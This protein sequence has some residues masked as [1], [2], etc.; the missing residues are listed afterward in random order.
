MSRRGIKLLKRAL[1]SVIADNRRREAKDRNVG[2]IWRNSLKGSAAERSAACRQ[3]QEWL[4]AIRLETPENRLLPSELLRVVAEIRK[5]AMDVR[6]TAN[7]R[8]TACGR[9]LRVEGFSFA[10]RNDEPTDKLLDKFFPPL[11]EKEPA[12]TTEMIRAQNRAQALQ[13]V[14]KNY[15]LDRN[16]G[17]F[18]GLSAEEIAQALR[19]DGMEPVAVP[20]DKG[21]RLLRE[22]YKTYPDIAPKDLK[23][24]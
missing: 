7:V 24:A 12:K 23:G 13:E 16:E 22:F 8:R 1:R 18:G 4:S 19:L 11:P 10:P 9:L 3:C 15:L 17:R 5:S 21:E 2:K 6:L 14:R 20:E